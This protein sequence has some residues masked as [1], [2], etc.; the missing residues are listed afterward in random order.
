MASLKFYI[1]PKSNPMTR[2]SYCCLA[3]L[4]VLAACQSP[5]GQ[6]NNASGDSTASAAAT[7]GTPD[8]HNSRNSL[9][10]AG[11]YSGILPCADCEALPTAVTLYSDGRY[12]TQRRYQGKSD[13]VFVEQ[14]NFTWS[15]DGNAILLD[16]NRGKYKVGEGSLL[17]LDGDG[18]IITGN[19]ADMYRFRQ[20]PHTIANKHWQLDAFHDTLVNV[21]KQKPPYLYFDDSTH[22]VSGHSS[23]NRV[24]GSYTEAGAGKIQFGQMIS[25]RMACPDMKTEAKFLDALGRVNS[26]NLSADTLLLKDEAGTVSLRL[27]L[28]PL[29]GK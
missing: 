5:N 17:Q 6:E 14:G 29:A 1:F 8:A 4:V 26:Y 13:S 9:D 19:L 23:C 2:I 15:E 24:S 12:T 25:T 28:K 10:W 20:V 21:G 11:T 3:A 22:R 16:N 7:A 27:L 18:N